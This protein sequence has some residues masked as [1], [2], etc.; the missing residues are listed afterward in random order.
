VQIVS[1]QA[2]NLNADPGERR[3]RMPDTL[4]WFVDHRNATDGSATQRH[5]SEA[6]P[7][8][9][10]AQNEARVKARHT[11]ATARSMTAPF[12]LLS[13]KRYGRCTVTGR[14]GQVVKTQHREDPA[15]SAQL[16]RLD[17]PP[18]RRQPI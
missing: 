11:V 18:A 10:K 4:S 5:P 3:Y 1:E 8:W 12:S 14:G 7:G 17:P 16:R 2:Q 13:G 15:I 6:F 9:R